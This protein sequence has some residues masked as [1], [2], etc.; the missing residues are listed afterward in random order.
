MITV[1]KRALTGEES[2]YHDLVES[3]GVEVLLSV[4]ESD[5]QGDSWYLLKDGRRYG[6][7]TFGWGSCS[8]CDAFE[9]ARYN[10]AE[11]T[12]VRDSL[13][14]GIHWE[15]SKAALRKYLEQKDWAVEWFASKSEFAQFR[16]KAAEVLA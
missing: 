2:G 9:A 8:G 13:E 11:L 3:I 15:S 10:A 16:S 14:S 4:D 7:L 1:K 5:Y 12:K 6:F